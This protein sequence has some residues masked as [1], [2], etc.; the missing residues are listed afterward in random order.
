VTCSLLAET[1]HDCCQSQGEAGYSHPVYSCPVFVGPW[2][3]QRKKGDDRDMGSFHHDQVMISSGLCSQQTL[4]TRSTTPTYPYTSRHVPK[5][6]Y[7]RDIPSMYIMLP[8]ILHLY[9][10]HLSTPTQL[11]L[12]LHNK[13]RPRKL[14]TTPCPRSNLPLS[15]SAT[16]HTL[17]PPA[18]RRSLQV[19]EGWERVPPIRMQGI[20]SAKNP[21]SSCAGNSS[22]LE[23]NRKK[24]RHDF[25]QNKP[26]ELATQPPS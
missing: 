19:W 6:C 16:R 5:C 21:R 2:R 22:L 20:R 14:M 17:S 23:N 7:P 12:P 3:R 18:R 25:L 8:Y 1:I 13:N 10:Y 4:C 11:H 15:P 9:R 26:S 24:C